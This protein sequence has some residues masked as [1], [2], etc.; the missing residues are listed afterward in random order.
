MRRIV[1]SPPESPERLRQAP[2]F[3][4]PISSPELPRFTAKN[5][6]LLP[7]RGR[8]ALY[9]RLP[10]CVPPPV[11]SS[12]APRG[13]AIECARPHGNIPPCPRPFRW[14]AAAQLHRTQLRSC[15]F[16]RFRRFACG[17]A[18]AP[19]RSAC[20]RAQIR[21]RPRTTGGPISVQA[22]AP[23]PCRRARSAS[24]VEAETI[25]AQRVARMSA[26]RVTWKS[27]LRNNHTTRRLRPRNHR[28]RSCGGCEN[29]DTGR[30]GREP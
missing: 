23:S 20:G 13:I 12:T 28:G 1:L 3:A 9:P 6:L 15:N 24:G 4:H 26:P 17:R 29:V 21:V 8:A 7:G 27:N 19:G 5:R 14:R 22:R 10:I 16:P 18:H 25:A 2:G 30:T 11:N